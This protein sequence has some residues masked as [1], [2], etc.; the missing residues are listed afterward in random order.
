[1]LA[2]SSGSG[3]TY[4]NDEFHQLS[5]AKLYIV[6]AD[7]SEPCSTQPFSSISHLKVNLWYCHNRNNKFKYSELFTTSFILFSQQKWQVLLSQ[8]SL[9]ETGNIIKYLR[10]ILLIQDK[11]EAT[12]RFREA[13]FFCEQLG[14][15]GG[16]SSNYFTISYMTF[17]MFI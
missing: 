6:F 17:K 5:S 13:G 16:T 8:S 3:H 11:R 4:E 1:M 9:F 7:K 12:R 10:F 2:S 14:T 15:F